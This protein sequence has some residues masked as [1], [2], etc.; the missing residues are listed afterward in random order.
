MSSVTFGNDLK[1]LR[2]EDAMAE[3]EWAPGQQS[4]LVR[5]VGQKAK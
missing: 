5:F 3:A 2:Y 1:I 4:R